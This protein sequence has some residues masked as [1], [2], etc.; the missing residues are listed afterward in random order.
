MSKILCAPT[1][2]VMSVFLWVS[3]QLPPHQPLP[4][5]GVVCDS[6][7][8]LQA[9]A[10]RHDAEAAYWHGVIVLPSHFTGESVAE[11]AVLAHEITHF[12]QDLTHERLGPDNG[13]DEAYA[14]QARY[15]AE[16]NGEL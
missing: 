8:L 9:S 4:H 3:A 14:I 13:E 1:A 10:G 15:E 16:H 11:Q 5:P 7:M 2:V 12:A 6:T